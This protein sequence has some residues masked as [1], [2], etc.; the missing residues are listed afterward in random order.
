MEKEVINIVWFK[1]DLRIRDHQPL[2]L[3]VE[4][5]QPTLLLY[6]FEPQLTQ[7]ADYDDRHGRFIFE[8]LIDLQGQLGAFGLELH[9][10]Y[11]EIIDT[12]NHIRHYFQIQHIYAHQETGQKVTFDRDI[13]VK[14]YCQTNHIKWIECLQDG[15]FRGL[16]NRKTWKVDFERF[17]NSGLIHPNLKHLKK[18]KIPAGLKAKLYRNP[19][20]K[21]FQQKVPGFQPGGATM[22]YRYLNSFFEKRASQYSRHLSKPELSRKSCSRLSPYIAFG[23]ISIREI[24][25]QSKSRQSHPELG[26]HLKNFQSRV[27]WR[28]H[29][30]QKL[31]SNWKMEFEPINSGFKQLDRHGNAAFFEAWRTGNTGEPMIDASM[32]CLLATG[33]INFR[34]RAMLATY[35]T[36][37]LWLDWKLVAT[38]LAKVFLDFEP[39]IHYPQFQMQAGLTGYHPLRIYNPLVQAEQHD[40]DGTFI[41][42]WVPEL[43]SIPPPLLFEPWKMT[44]LDQSFFHCKIGKHYPAPIVDYNKSTKINKDKY[45]IIRNLEATKKELPKIWHR[46]C[47]PESIQ[48]YKKNLP[49]TIDLD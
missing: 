42:K 32:R 18:L 17:I 28:S 7:K 30:M 13:A 44:P 25:R 33:W 3:A 2:Q 46:L 26:W 38:H 45:W 16:K 9:F 21:K 10:I 14:R 24:W 37:T 6:C 4:N 47:L 22:A 15:V 12:L 34:M 36:F 31:E 29:Y 20:P 27:W 39:G 11:N 48:S 49:G 8:S 19:I 35:A 1:R 5:Q 40:P 43:R 41:K 23:N